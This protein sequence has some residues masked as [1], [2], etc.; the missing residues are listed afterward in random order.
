MSLLHAIDEA[1]KMCKAEESRLTESIRQSKDLLR[2]M[3]TRVTDIS[4]LDHAAAISTKD[5]VAPK[6]QQEIELLDKVL[7]KALKIRSASEGHKELSSDGD[8]KT[9]PNDIRNKSV[10]NHKDNDKRKPGQR[11]RSTGSSVN[12][13]GI[14]TRPVSVQKAR[15][16]FA[17]KQSAQKSAPVKISSTGSQQK[18]CDE[19]INAKEPLIDQSM[20]RLC[21]D[22]P[23]SKTG[24]S[25]SNEQWIQSPL[26]PVWRSQRAK[27]I[28]LCNKV[29]T[30]QSKSVPERDHFTERLRSTFPSEWPSGCPAD[31]KAKL[32]E[33]T[34]RCLDLTHC[35]H[36]ELSRCTYQGC[37]A[38]SQP[39]SSGEKWFESSLMLQGLEK[40]TEELLTS[41]DRLK[42][43]W[44][45][46]N[47]CHSETLCPVR[48][49]GEWG[50]PDC[51]CLPPVLSYT[52]ETELR[53]LETQRLQVEQLQQA[54]S[55]QQA[56]SDNL[57]SYWTM[58]D[59]GTERPSA[60]V[61]RG[62]Y[63]LLA[64]GGLQFPS[65][66]LDSE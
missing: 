43:D 2:S 22:V 4:G 53:Q 17:G 42:K 46:W 38:G 10:I 27:Q 66:V 31:I 45:R 23:V 1:I 64:E 65:L 7:K 61:L 5:D 15:M 37:P 3:R 49:K 40:M 28:R 54:V 50:D 62:L 12:S 51:P 19:T 18:I 59:S 34:R 47:K 9:P 11:V 14:L 44:E 26:L 52:S 6:E 35:F 36:A 41:A 55:L 63:S 56:M 29:L 33:L 60:V 58:M 20:K 8:I 48:R 24:T 21:E 32:D 39:G 13:G 30:H 16:V 57:A 25:Q